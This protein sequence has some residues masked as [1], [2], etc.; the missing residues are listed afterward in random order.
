M[1][2]GVN[3]WLEAEVEGNMICLINTAGGI[4][5]EGMPKKTP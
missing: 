1:P 5:Y 2:T 3:D 4:G